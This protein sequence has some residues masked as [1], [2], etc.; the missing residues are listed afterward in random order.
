LEIISAYWPQAPVGCHKRSE[1]RK[2]GADALLL[3]VV[4]EAGD[5]RLQVVAG[6]R[7]RGLLLE[8]VVEAGDL[9]LRVVAG[10]R[11]CALLLHVAARVDAHMSLLQAVVEIRAPCSTLRYPCFAP[12]P[13][14]SSSVPVPPCFAAAPSCSAPASSMG[15]TVMP[16]KSSIAVTPP[17]PLG[18]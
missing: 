13:A 14:A 16:P 15:V 2:W 6:A 1:G 18:R 7:A 4:G 11:A 9:H 10:A 17:A 3:E 8:V 5:L 12:T